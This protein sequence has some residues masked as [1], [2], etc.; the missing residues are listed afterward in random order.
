MRDLNELTMESDDNNDDTDRAYLYA[1]RGEQSWIRVVDVKIN[2]RTVSFQV[3]TGAEIT[4][5]F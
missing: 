3:D 5:V 1:V 2:D 4:A